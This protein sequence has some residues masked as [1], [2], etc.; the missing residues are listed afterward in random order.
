MRV[1]GG[2][3]RRRVAA[4]AAL[5]LA[6]LAGCTVYRQVM[7]EATVSLEGAD[8][9]R[10][11]ADIRRPVK[12]ICPREP[13]QMWV[14]VDA[15]LPD[16]TDVSRLE[17]W[18]G[19]H[20]ARRNG[21]LDFGN[22]VFTSGQGAVDEFGWFLPHRDMLLSAERGF[23]I[24]TA[25]RF[26]PEAHGQSRAYPPDYRCVRTAGG[27]APPGRSGDAGASGSRGANGGEEQAGWRGD[28]G[29]HGE[30]GEPGPPGPRL[31]AYAT[32]VRTPFFERL[33]AV[34]IEGTL[35]DLVLAPS[36]QE[37]LLLARGGPGG[38]GG[39]GGPGG[40]GGDGGRGRPGRPGGPG[41][42]GGNGGP[43]GD[44]G[45]GG[46]LDLVYDGRFPDLARL[47]RL[48]AGGGPGGP[49]GAGGRGGT[50]GSGGRGRDG[51]RNGRDGP[52]GPDGSDGYAG[53]AGPP[54]TARVRPG[55]VTERFRG[56]PGI[57]P[58]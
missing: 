19:D 45:P 11:E 26:R 48:D 13:V 36:D 33:V 47:I 2:R 22:F 28:P 12:A 27:L 10:M 6:G 21:A 4:G 17:T 38:S 40:G 24:R 31:Q 39:A 46:A 30:E 3:R 23:E 55:A 41:A 32:Y 56:L 20:R 53:R 44:G 52:S 50:G 37:L 57:R 5:A 15:R 58:Y 14:T 43:G 29:H 25:L 8:V 7:G 35:P 51:A 34:R 18:V 42:P 49:G 54:G 1:T 16:R 9:Q